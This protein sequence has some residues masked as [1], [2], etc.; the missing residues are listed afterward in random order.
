M[1]C[2]YA[3][4]RRW[5]PRVSRAPP[6]DACSDCLRAGWAPPC[7]RLGDAAAWG[8]GLEVRAHTPTRAAVGRP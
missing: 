2:I 5:G 1:P 6:L 7:G 3:T 4:V 8:V